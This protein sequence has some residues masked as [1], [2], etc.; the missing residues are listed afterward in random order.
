MMMESRILDTES[1][2]EDT[3]NSS[4][5]VNS[6]MLPAWNTNGSHES[7]GP[8]SG[9]MTGLYSFQKLVE[10][11]DEYFRIIQVPMKHIWDSSGD[12]LP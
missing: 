4:T 11:I 9:S 8:P 12:S 2:D 5:K 3:L 1:K 10:C 7:A 6:S